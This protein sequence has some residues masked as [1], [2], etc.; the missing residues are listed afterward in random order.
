M[1]GRGTYNDKDKR[2]VEVMG[3]FMA[4]H[5]LIT[6][7]SQH[8]RSARQ[9]G[10]ENPRAVPASRQFYGP[11][12]AKAHSDTGRVGLLQLAPLLLLAAGLLPADASMS[13]VG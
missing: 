7:A 2:R 10:R 11:Q 9:A 13:N 5:P 1:L 12:E 4:R 8:E 3:F 6:S